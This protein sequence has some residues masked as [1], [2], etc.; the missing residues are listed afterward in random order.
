MPVCG[1]ERLGVVASGLERS[2]QAKTM[3]TGMLNCRSPRYRH[4]ANPLGED[5]PRQYRAEGDRHGHEYCRDVVDE[6]RQAATSNP[7]LPAYALAFDEANV[8]WTLKAAT[9]EPNGRR[10]GEAKSIRPR[11]EAACCGAG[12]LVST[13]AHCTSL[14]QKRLLASDLSSL[15]AITPELGARRGHRGRVCGLSKRR[16]GDQRDQCESSDEFPHDTSPSYGRY[17]WAPATAGRPMANAL[18]SW[19]R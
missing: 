1:T 13:A 6:L 11:D 4:P 15:V 3:G 2:A 5:Q 17:P 19:G 18:Q 16:D 10:S 8:A 12:R 7:R 14:N 9:H